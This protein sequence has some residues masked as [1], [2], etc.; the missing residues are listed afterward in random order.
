MRAS[1]LNAIIPMLLY[2]LAFAVLALSLLSHNQFAAASPLHQTKQFG[3]SPLEYSASFP[4]H[5]LSRRATVESTDEIVAMI[6]KHGQ[7]GKKPSVFWT[8]FYQYPG[9]EAYRRVREWGNQ[10]FGG[11][12]NYK[13]Y[14]DLL[15][16]SDY[17]EMMSVTRTTEEQ[18]L[19]I[20]HMSKAF[21]RRS[22][23]TV[24]LLIPE[25]QQPG[26]DSVWKLWEAPTLTRRPEWVDEIIRVDFPS[27][28][29]ESFWKKGQA[30]L[31]EA[32][33]PGKV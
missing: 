6:D 30:A 26:D 19:L 5:D 1:L 27:G 15:A 3:T 13:L 23:G 9:P 2:R 7:V 8:S 4:I 32:A 21:A 17:Q 22:K 25:G 18:N 11:R 29:E 10:K 33:P 14:T 12:C 28:K 16:D 24:Y 20:R 31:Y